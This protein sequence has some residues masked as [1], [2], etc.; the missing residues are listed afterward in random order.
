MPGALMNA[1]KALAKDGHKLNTGRPQFVHVGTVP[2]DPTQGDWYAVAFHAHKSEG[3]QGAL[4]YA[5]DVKNRIV[6]P[7]PVFL[8]ATLLS[9]EQRTVEFSIG[10][11]PGQAVGRNTKFVIDGKNHKVTDEQGQEIQPPQRPLNRAS[12]LDQKLKL[13]TRSAIL[14]F[15]GVGGCLYADLFHLHR[16]G[17]QHSVWCRVCPRGLL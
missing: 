3:Q 14:P 2:D 16:V 1:R 15:G 7:D 11:R 5:V 8:K 10:Y 13:A 9:A 6:S 4:V 17:R 12:S